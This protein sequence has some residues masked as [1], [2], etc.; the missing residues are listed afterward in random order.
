MEISTASNL[1]KITGNI[2]SVNDF[3]QIKNTLDTL[4][5]NSSNITIEIKESISITSSVI[6]YLNKLVLKDK[7]S[8]NLKIGNQQLIELLDDLNLTKVFNIKKV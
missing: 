1:V 5:S 2:K 3:Q 4:K 7:V 6:G 8:L